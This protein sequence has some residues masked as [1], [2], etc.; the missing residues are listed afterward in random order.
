MSLQEEKRPLLPTADTG[1][2]GSLTNLHSEQ[3]GAQRKAPKVPGI[4]KRYILTFLGFLGFVNVYALRVN[5]SVALVEMVTLNE[6][7]VENATS[8]CPGPNNTD[9]PDVYRKGEFDWSP[10]LQGIILGSFFYGYVT[11]Q[12]PGGWIAEN[13]GG[14]KLFGFGVLCTSALT[15]LTPVAARLHVG[16]LILIRILE[17]IGEGV[18][19]PAM[20][21]MFGKWAPVWERSRLVSITYAGAQMGTVVSLPI[22]GILCDSHIF[23]GWPAVFYIFGAVGCLW[24]VVWMFMVA[25]T[26]A[27]H[28]TISTEERDFIEQSIGSKP[29]RERTPWLGIFTS[30]PFWAIFIAHFCNN[31]GFYTLLTCLPTYLSEVLHF[32]IKENGL[33]SALPYFC[34]WVTMNVTGF[35]VDY[36]R[37]HRYLSTVHARKLATSLGFLFPGGF[38]VA[39]GYSGCNAT[40]D[41]AFLTLALGLSG[42]YMS[43]FI[44]NHLDIAP[45]FSGTLMGLTNCFGTLPGFL[46][47]ILAGYLT[48]KQ[49]TSAQWQKV[50]YISCG[51]YVFGT[52]FYLAFASGDIQKW[53]QPKSVTIE[54][55]N[56]GSDV[57][58][59]SIQNGRSVTPLPEILTGPD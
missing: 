1:D 45:K 30:M 44:V 41:V 52:V 59:K 58:N 33:L 32:N 28:S 39:A 51:I 22:S 6:T 19:F 42:I 55:N 21:A 37:E 26:P 53:A 12:I 29:Q 17:G 16:V 18:T 5:L 11:T 25:D 54:V 43:G 7:K 8:E 56:D 36:L 14:K 13:F 49:Q 50:F 57:N 4:P 27:K 35:V 20:H 2:G 23:G 10:S 40:L 31:W 38:L 24:F 47:P 48:D 9:V 46:G 34:C 15:L 3:E